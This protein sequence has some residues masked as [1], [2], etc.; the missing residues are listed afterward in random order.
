MQKKGTSGLVKA[1]LLNAL[2]T[3]EKIK[4]LY[5]EPAPHTTRTNL[6]DDLC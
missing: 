3:T 4:K 6:A 5:A 2:Q 1:A